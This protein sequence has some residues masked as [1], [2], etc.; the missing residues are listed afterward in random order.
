MFWPS[1]VILSAV[2]AGLS[3]RF[4]DDSEATTGL[5]GSTDD[6]QRMSNANVSVAAY[7]SFRS[8]YLAVY[9]CMMSTPCYYIAVLI[10][11]R[12]GRLAAGTVRLPALQGAPCRY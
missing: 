1:F 10:S 12:S 4:R 2:C 5:P 9:L 8:N 7:R 11:V 3:Y 6:K